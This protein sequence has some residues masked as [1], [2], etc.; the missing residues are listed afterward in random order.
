MSDKIIFYSSSS[1]TFALN[2]FKQMFSKACEY[3]IRATIFVAKQ[4]VAGRKVGL[5]EIADSIDSPEAFT[6]KILQQLAK[7]KIIS[8]AKGPTG[9]YYLEEYK[10]EKLRLVEIVYAIDGDDVYKGCGLGLR[11]CNE[12]KPCPLHYEFKEI[13]DNLKNMLERTFVKKL[14][15][16]NEDSLSFLK[17]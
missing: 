6:A 11:K 4:S 3:G 8:S 1:F 16:E 12:K 14:A 13:R 10:L 2:Y 9:G 7:S 15:A 5:I 17:R